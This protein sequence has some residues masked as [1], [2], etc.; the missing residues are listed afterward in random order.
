MKVTAG[1]LFLS[2]SIALS[3]PVLAAD[4]LHHRITLKLDPQ[5]HR[6][7]A[8][9]TIS[10]LGVL[11]KDSDGAYR[12]LLH[13]GLN[14]HVRGESWKI[15]KTSEKG[16]SG[17]LGIN[18]T[19]E[20]LSGGPGLEA[21]CLVPGDGADAE[22]T[23][24][25]SGEIH[26]PLALQG[27]EYQRAF[28]E[29]P[30]TIGPEGVFLSGTTY[31]VPSFGDQLISFEVEVR[32]VPENWEIISQGGRIVDDEID[33][34]RITT[35]KADFPTEEIYIV[36]GPLF[37]FAD[38]QGDTDVFA[39]L[40]SEDPALASRYLSATKR[41]LRM[42]ESILPEYPF[43]SFALVENFWETGYGMPGFTLL[44]PKI[45]RFPWILTSSY[46][47]ELL[48]NWWGNSVYVD[49][50]TGN[51][52]EGLT[53]YMADHMLAEQR[54]E[55]RIYRRTT[56][57]KFSDL[58][59]SDNDFP[60]TQFHARHSAASEAIG[61]GKALM[62]FHMM[63][64]SVGDEEFR[65]AVT[66]FYKAN[67]FKRASFGDIAAAF[68]HVGGPVLA[69]FV[70]AWTERVSA[71]RI[72]LGTT[73][74]KEN[75]DHSFTLTVELSQAGDDE[76]FPL[77]IPI[78][79]TIE[80]REEALWHV[81]N[82]CGAHCVV[83]ISCPGKPLRVDIDPAFDLM[84]RLDPLE[85]PPAISTV[86]GAKDAL[87]VLPSRAPE[88]ELKAWKELADSFAAPEKART[89]LDSE[90]EDFPTSA[91]WILGRDNRFAGEIPWRLASRGVGLDGEKIRIGDEEIASVGASVVLIARDPVDPEIAA[92]YI[93]A[94]PVAAI[95]GLARKLPHYQKYSYLLFKGPEPSNVLKGMWEPEDSPLVKNLSNGPMPSLHLEKRSPLAAM[96][97]LFAASDFEKT[98]AFLAAPSLEGRG[99]GSKGLAR[100]TDY[101]E[102]KIKEIGLEPA[103]SE[104]FR[105][106]WTIRAGEPEREM[107][108]T[109][110][111]GKI[112]GT[113]PTLDP[114]VVTAHLDHLGLGWPDVRA[115]NEGKI[116]PGADDNAS[117]VAVLLELA[118][119]LKAE[120]PRPRSV[121]FAVVTGEEA[122]LLG[123]RH[124]VASLKGRVF[125]N[126]NIDTVGRLSEGALYVLNTSSAREWRFIFMGVGYT[127]GAPIKI[128][129]EPLDASDQGSFL[130]AG[131][132]AVQLFTGPTPDYHRPT[133][134]ADKLD[135]AGM[136]T[137][138][139]AAK[140]C[141]AYLA[142]RKEPLD[143]R[144]SGTTGGQERPPESSP[145]GQ[146]E[147]KTSLGT[148]PD[149]GYSGPG[150]R[151]QAV[152]PGSAAQDAGIE[153][154]DILLALGGE[155]IDGLK[156]LS[157]LLK[158]HAVG[159]KVTLAVQRGHRKLEVEV[160][161]KQR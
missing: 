160:V 32:D 31:W 129:S 79:V 16:D 116:H 30:G 47:H 119:A 63:R 108:L 138:C 147:R 110:L 2:L 58:V 128:V 53:A 136:S 150:V 25:Y 137:V 122:G 52:C 27:E 134:T 19:T 1:L 15:E 103:G 140:E 94:D 85:V 57:K 102:E 161:L 22:I 61:Y 92:G 64:R 84:R 157:E 7:N 148:M 76:P 10:H 143:V 70:K 5:E 26:H 51:W 145:P 3:S 13:E 96:P 77:E 98:V 60:L 88:D 126:I 49:F 127:T 91:F 146:S 37:S 130:E 149:F 99:L 41:Y 29:T 43:P 11:P 48:H 39:F 156:A 100:A 17:F 74:V 56:L 114:V 80:D 75:P 151:V 38:R 159:D 93:A 4:V 123:S 144:L 68:Y 59:D 35:W 141:L 83:E 155:D 54:G 158:R 82:A 113:D 21:W 46:P 20:N 65:R 132:P 109:N 18:S 112:P 14:P 55:G 105:Q 73:E 9:D 40:R 107:E 8:V 45:I 120:S 33:G 72:V 115:G 139:E 50:S 131:I 106:S 111:I 153:K 6:I 12:F 154:G 78:A 95:A 28:S 24:V 125:A 135:Y 89:I 62:L 118:R 69:P 44:G 87:F 42:Y 152:M 121:L 86:M 66:R 133:D 67:Q 23:L 71:P 81:E 104:G 142:E 34:V 90:M 101:V 117:G 36:G 124:L 97:P